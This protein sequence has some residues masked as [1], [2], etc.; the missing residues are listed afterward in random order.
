MS[1][2]NW[3]MENGYDKNLSIGRIDVDGNYEP[4]NCRWVNR[5]IQSRNTRKIMSTN[6]SGYRGVSKNRKRWR[7]QIVVSKK[8]VSIGSFNNPYCA[9][10]HY[11]AFVIEN[12]LEHTLNIN[13]K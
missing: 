1:F 12:N 6:K 7:A 4:K 8:R 10:L 13:F 3:S 11:D 5:D 9:S 2:Y